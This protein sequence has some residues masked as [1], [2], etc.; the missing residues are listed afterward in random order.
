MTAAAQPAQKQGEAVIEAEHL[1]QVESTGM[2][3]TRTAVPWWK[4]ELILNVLLLP[5]KP[6]RVQYYEIVPKRAPSSAALDT[7]R[8]EQEESNG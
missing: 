7:G 5:D 2:A 1:V 6:H 8:T 4:M 3:H